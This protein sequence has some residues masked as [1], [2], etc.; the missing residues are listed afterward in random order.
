MHLNF[1]WII[2][3]ESYWTNY[4]TDNFFE[5]TNWML[6]RNQ[7]FLWNKKFCRWIEILKVNLHHFELK[8]QHQIKDSVN[9]L[10]C[11]LFYGV[12]GR[13][14]ENFRMYSKYYFFRVSYL[15]KHYQQKTTMMQPVFESSALFTSIPPTMEQISCRSMPA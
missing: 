7:T 11:F 3:F 6:V 15:I 2:A 14:H 1:D 13:F 10:C 5:F 9:I 4:L 12:C 8:N